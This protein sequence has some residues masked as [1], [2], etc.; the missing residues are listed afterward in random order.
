MDEQSD[1][2]TNTAYMRLKVIYQDLDRPIDIMANDI[3]VIIL[4]I[5]FILVTFRGALTI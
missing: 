3:M 2:Q 4:H 1:G 5:V